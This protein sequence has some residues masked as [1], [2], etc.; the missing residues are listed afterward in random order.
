MPIKTNCPHMLKFLTTIWK[1]GRERT[2]EVAHLTLS[3]AA[4]VAHSLIHLKCIF[5]ED[6]TGI[7]GVVNFTCCLLDL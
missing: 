6:T 7:H 5:M 2:L 3:M 1:G 4:D